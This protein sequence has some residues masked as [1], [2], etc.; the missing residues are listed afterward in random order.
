MPEPRIEIDYQGFVDALDRFVD[1]TDRPARILDN[2][3]RLISAVASPPRDTGRLAGSQKFTVEGDT[4]AVSWTAPYARYPH[5]GTRHM[6][7]QPWASQA[8]EQAEQ[9]VLQTV[10]DG[11]ADLIGRNGHN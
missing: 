6:S 8:V 4:G 11:V 3:T 9:K 2:S 10:R 7:A 1:A 5:W